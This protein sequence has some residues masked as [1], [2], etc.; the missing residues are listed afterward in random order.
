MI[1]WL[2]ATIFVDYAW[3]SIGG[4]FGWFGGL[5]FVLF[6]VFCVYQITFVLRTNIRKYARQWR[7]QH[8]PTK[9]VQL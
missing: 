3:F 4:V 1:P 2:L 6:M 8:S 5:V 9:S 7:D